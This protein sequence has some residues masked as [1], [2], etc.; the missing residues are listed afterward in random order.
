MAVILLCGALTSFVVEEKKKGLLATDFL[1][2]ICRGAPFRWA[3][4]VALIQPV[5]RRIASVWKHKLFSGF[6]GCSGSW[7]CAYA[8]CVRVRAARGAAP[9]GGGGGGGGGDE[10]S[11][12]AN[13]EGGDITLRRAILRLA[14]LLINLLLV[15]WLWHGWRAHAALNDIRDEGEPEE[16]VVRAAA[17]ELNYGRF[18]AWKRD[19]K[20]FV[21]LGKGVGLFGFLA[22]VFALVDL[23]S[24]TQFWEATESLTPWLGRGVV[25]KALAW[26]FHAPAVWG[27]ACDGVAYQP[28]AQTVILLDDL[29]GVDR[30][31]A[32]G[33]KPKTDEDLLAFEV[34]L[35]GL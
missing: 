20:R 7:Q 17:T 22:P 6:M 28:L 10:K 31:E 33:K 4:R 14:A 2:Q 24:S 34:A 15:L 5:L 23:V 32:Q 25:G 12:A 29:S 3:C 11:G 26:Y 30:E 19:A 35:G 16:D 1:K 13:A 18:E 8:A 21:D 27:A 9:G